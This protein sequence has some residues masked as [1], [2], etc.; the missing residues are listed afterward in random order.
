LKSKEQ[1]GVQA[2]QCALASE[3]DSIDSETEYSDAVRPDGKLE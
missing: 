1:I 3:T 2:K